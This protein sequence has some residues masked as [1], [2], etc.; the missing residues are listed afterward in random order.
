MPATPNAALVPLERIERAILLI[1]GQKVMLDRDLAALYG[2]ETR[3][4][5]QAVRRN[6]RRFPPDF[7]LALTR[8]EIRDI[9]QFVTCPGFKHARS[10]FA[11]TEQGVAM[12]SGVLNSG[13]A[14]EV[15]IAIMRAFVKLRE[16]L[17][18]H[19]DLALKLD[20]LE[21]RYDA[22]FKVVFDALRQLMAPPA[23]KSRRRI[24]FGVKEDPGVYRYAP[25]A[26]TTGPGA[27]GEDEA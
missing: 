7:M 13:R 10:A 2:V 25:L 8:D 5:N 15:N 19:A 23:R 9:S 26:C 21:Q 16:L 1:R 22:Q 12:L 3:V 6:L 11:F 18:S 24:G 14:V 20:E 4:L 27:L 17:A